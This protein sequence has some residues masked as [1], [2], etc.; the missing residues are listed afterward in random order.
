[1]HTTVWFLSFKAISA[2]CCLRSAF[3]A[4]SRALSVRIVIRVDS[5][6]C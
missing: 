6:C 5:N 3:S 1:M 2:S 4:L